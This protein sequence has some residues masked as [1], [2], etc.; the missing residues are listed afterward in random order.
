MSFLL[1]QC[2][3]IRLK[4]MFFS[5]VRKKHGLLVAQIEH[6]HSVV[7]NVSD[8]Q[9]CLDAVDQ[10][11]GFL[12]RYL[13]HQAHHDLVVALLNELWTVRETSPELLPALVNKVL[14]QYQYDL[15]KG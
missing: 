3:P 6:T 8:Y 11:I 9:T 5:S 13:R 10:L 2:F 4:F 12:L 7:Q 15:F 1:W 14:Q